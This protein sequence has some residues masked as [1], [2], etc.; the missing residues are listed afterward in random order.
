MQITVPRT[1]VTSYLAT[2][3]FCFFIRHRKDFNCRTLRHFRYLDRK[4]V[5]TIEAS[6]FTV[7]KIFFSQRCEYLWIGLY[8]FVRK[9]KPGFAIFCRIIWTFDSCMIHMIERACRYIHVLICLPPLR[10]R[11]D[12]LSTFCG[13]SPPIDSHLLFRNPLVSIE[14]GTF[15]RMANMRRPF[16]LAC[17]SH[18]RSSSGDEEGARVPRHSYPKQND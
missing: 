1:S 9:D 10:E 2:L 12:S 7:R 16:W 8:I 13:L 18:E 4:G 17:S 3:Q 15:A 14:R 5:S 11:V 6:R